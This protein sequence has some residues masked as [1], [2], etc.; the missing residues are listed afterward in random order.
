M[1]AFAAQYQFAASFTVFLVALAGL[2]LVVLREALTTRAGARVA[3]GVGFVGIGTGAFLSG[4]L[5]VTDG[6]DPTVLALRVA[7]V[8]ALV[9]GSAGWRGSPL[10]RT[11][12]LSGAVGL[13]VA[14]PL[15][16]GGLANVAATVAALG[17]LLVGAALIAASRVAIAARVAASAAATLLLVVLVLSVALSAVLGRTVED[18]ALA[19]LDGRAVIEVGA[20]ESRARSVLDKAAVTATL[21]AVLRQDR[22]DATSAPVLSSIDP[23]VGPTEVQRTALQAELDRLRRD[24]FSDIGFALVAPDRRILAASGDDP[25]LLDGAAASPVVEQALTATPRKG[26]LATLVLGGGAVIVAVRPLDLEAGG[27][28]I[29]AVVGVA[30]IDDAYLDV[31]V[32]DGAADSLAVVASGGTVVARSGALP[33]ARVLRDLATEVLGPRSRSRAVTGDRYASARAVRNPTGDGAPVLAVVASRSTERVETVRADLFKTFFVIAFGGTVLALLLAAVV[34]DRIGAGIRR[35]TSSAEA[36]Q[37]GELGVRSGVRS[38]DEVGVLGA[39]F[40]SMAASIEEQTDA[41]QEAAQRVEAIVAGMGEA[42]IALDGAGRITDFNGA[43]EELLELA[44]AEA[45]GRSVDEVLTLT[46]EDGV[47]LTARVRALEPG[48]W[49]ALG[50]VRTR[51]GTAVPVAVTAGALRGPDGE[52]AGG[53]IV[54]RDLRGEREVERMKRHF[55]SRVGHELRTPLTPLIGYSQ[56]LAGRELPPERARPVYESILSSAKRLER[57]VE[58]L[59]FFASLDAGRQVLRAEPVDV[60]EVLASVVARRGPA[61]AGTPHTLVKRVARDTPRVNVDGRWLE[62]SIDELV[63]NAVKFSPAGG[64]VQVTA[65]PLDDDPTT[66]EIAVRDSGVGMSPDEVEAAFLEWAQGDESDTRHFGGL[67]LGLA[68][69]QRVAEHHGGRV[70]CTTAPGKGARFAILLPALQEA[71]PITRRR[72]SRAVT[73]GRDRPRR[74][75][76]R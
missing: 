47:D 26:R 25:S 71:A 9:V 73:S 28:P 39:T 7:G 30:A 38:E 44:G 53:V 54:L 1:P 74:T 36:I 35:L 40:D 19:E 68:L 20:V 17:G 5:L 2:A 18:Q 8:A 3:L 12:L 11:L 70:V 15:E 43:A 62:R 46:A 57:I 33:P 34:G 14:A 24:V 60:R 21:L 55:L 32:G 6:A 13:L 63:D 72:G 65:G 48:R 41:L 75:D 50:D 69:V 61:L 4:S 16:L 10:S 45:Q 58:M 52:V 29:G 59:E 56:L 37:R 31:R 27:G 64:R 67:G 76:G 66:V 42:L 22:E 49:S 51:T 23:K